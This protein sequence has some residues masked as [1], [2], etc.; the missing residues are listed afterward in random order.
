MILRVRLHHLDDI[1]A[2]W[3]IINNSVLEKCKITSEDGFV[4]P[5]IFSDLR[6][7]SMLS[8]S[9]SSTVE[10]RSLVI[11][12]IP[13][14]AGTMVLRCFYLIQLAKKTWI[15]RTMSATYSTVN[16]ANI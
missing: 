4:A 8:I 11:G 7:H 9:P 14:D 12:S 16:P 6:G 13:F 1:M 10:G 15:I 2:N 3:C 5:E